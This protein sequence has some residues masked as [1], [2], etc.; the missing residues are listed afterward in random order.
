LDRPGTARQTCLFAT[1]LTSRPGLLQFKIYNLFN[2][3][4]VFKVKLYP[5]LLS[6]LIG[7]S[8][9]VSFPMDSSRLS[10]LLKNLD[11]LE[12]PQNYQTSNFNSTILKCLAVG[13]I[14]AA[15]IAAC[16]YLIKKTSMNDPNYRQFKEKRA[17]YFIKKQGCGACK[18]IEPLIE[19]IQKEYRNRLPINVIEASQAY[20][21][22]IGVERIP[23]AVYVNNYKQVTTQVGK[24]ITHSDITQ[25]I[26]DVLEIPAL[27]N[28]GISS[29][30]PFDV[31]VIGA[32][33]AGTSAASYAARNNLKTILFGK[34]TESNLAGLQQVNNWP[35]MPEIIGSRL[36]FDLW[37]QAMNTDVAIN[38]EFVVA[39]DTS[40]RPFTLTTNKNKQYFAQTI[41]LATGK[42]PK[43]ID[44]PGI[45]EYWGKG[46]AICALCDAASYKDKCV[47][48]YGQSNINESLEQLAHLTCKINLVIPEPEVINQ[49]TKDLIKK[50]NIT[51]I[52]Q[53]TITKID[54]NK[55]H[56]TDINIQIGKRNF[57]NLIT[58]AVFLGLENVPNND[59]AR[60]IIALDE[61]GFIL[62]NQSQETSIKGIFAA[63]DISNHPYKQAF[64]ASSQ[65]LTAAMTAFKFLQDLK[66]S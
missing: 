38:D 49:D 3:N 30:N 2:S 9:A 28:F 23:M 40:R 59:I 44:I 27:K 13:G 7:L 24:E 65:G 56:V 64:L 53:A 60:N 26:N 16:Y 52:K 8:S 35:G 62:V 58:D 45:M 41:I 25:T 66:R 18:R 17:L 12:N 43:K 19:Q 4:G 1:K 6:I 20:K 34:Q 32:G 63:G 54:G 61:K 48:I 37:L 50:H 15:G 21:F 51:V 31:A 47:T 42:T 46:V 29:N 22:N 11:Y 10:N 33:P 14:A 57:P 36:S 39:I 5:V 55:S